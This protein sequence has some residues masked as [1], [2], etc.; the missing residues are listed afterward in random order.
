MCI[1]TILI[2]FALGFV[3]HKKK[4]HWS[5]IFFLISAVVLLVGEVLERPLNHNLMHPHSYRTLTMPLV[6]MLTAA[7]TFIELR[8]HSGKVKSFSVQNALAFTALVALIVSS[9]QDFRLTQHWD[10]GIRATRN[11]ME[12]LGPGCH[13]ISITDPRISPMAWSINYDGF[14][15]LA[16]LIQGRR[17][18][19]ALFIKEFETAANGCDLLISNAQIL[20]FPNAAN[21]LNCGNYFECI[22]GENGPFRDLS[23]IKLFED[24]Q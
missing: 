23:S 14:P 16:L 17:P 19:A 22:R 6:L 13:N 4:S 8:K 7:I 20:T 2:C 3:I 1:S 18:Q 21:D 9:L 11:T 12:N 15:A 5:K 10:E 24:H